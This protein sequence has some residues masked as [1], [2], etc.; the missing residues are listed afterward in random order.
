[1]ESCE[2]ASV[3]FV[4]TSRFFFFSENEV[5]RRILGLNREEATG[6]GEDYTKVIFMLCTRLPNIVRVMKSRRLK[7][8]GHVVLIAVR[9]DAYRG[10]AGKRG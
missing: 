2:T 7:W 6:N 8:T 4:M 1:M 5:L 10:L 3:V 9:R